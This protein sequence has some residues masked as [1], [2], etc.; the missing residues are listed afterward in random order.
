MPSRSTPA[1]RLR[2]RSTDSVDRAMKDLVGIGAVR[3]EHRY[4]GAQGLTNAY[5]VRTS[6]PGPT[7][8]FS[9]PDVGSRE[10][11]PTRGRRGGG[12]RKDAGGVAAGSGYYREHLTDRPSSAATEVSD[13]ESP[14]APTQEVAIAFGIEDWPTFIEEVQRRRSAL[15]APVTRW[16]GPC[17]AASL[18]LATR[19]PGWPADQAAAALLRVAAGP[20]TRSPMRLPEAD[21]WWDELPRVNP[22]SDLP[23]MERAL[24]EAGGLRIHL[25]VRA[26]RKL[27]QQ[28]VPVTRAGVIRGAFRLLTDGREGGAAR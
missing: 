21:P 8:S 23:G 15:G 25:Q 24:L 10:S 27:A 18:Q 28:G 3:I 5:Q 9:L 22:D 16:A 7:D 11:A 2:K 6:R 12:G 4:D 17:L 19:G 14:T 1:R 26:R 20:K 13:I